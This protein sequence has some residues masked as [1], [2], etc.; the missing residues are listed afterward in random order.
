MFAVGADQAVEVAAMGFDEFMDFAMNP[1][2]ELDK[3]WGG[4]GWLLKTVGLDDERVLYGEILDCVTDT[5]FPLFFKTA[6]EVQR[7]STELGPVGEEQLRE[8]FDP[9]ALTRDAVY[10]DVW[11]DDDVEDWIVAMTIE[12]RDMFLRCA[13]EGLCV[14]SLMS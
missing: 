6:D 11:D 1:D 9:V 12:V 4:V 5:G 3:A 7:I 8:A 2:L 14:I 13:T 10:P